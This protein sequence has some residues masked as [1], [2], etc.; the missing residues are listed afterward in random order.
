LF[1]SQRMERGLCPWKKLLNIKKRVR[2]SM[3]SDK[4]KCD[5]CGFIIIKVNQIWRDGFMRHRCRPCVNVE[6]QMKQREKAKLLK[7]SRRF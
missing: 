5:S 7:E 2:V 6:Q 1:T 3:W 4:V